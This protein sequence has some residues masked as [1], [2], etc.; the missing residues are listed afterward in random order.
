ME[1]RKV[2]I[3]DDEPDI[4]EILELL[5]TSDGYKVFLSADGENAIRLLKENPLMDLII[6]DVM[7]PHEDGI[8]VLRKIR[9]FS[10]IPALFL[11]AK[12]QESDKAEAYASG[13]DDFLEKPF[14]QNELLM[15]V[16]SLIRR[17]RDYSG[18]NSESVVTDVITIDENLKRAYKSGALLNLT[19]TEFDMLKFF[20]KNRG[21]PVDTKTLYEAVWDEKYVASAQNTIMVHILNLRKKIEDDHTNPVFLK[22][23][24]GKGYQFD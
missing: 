22:T 13:G 4:R 5:L 16:N 3:V 23:I 10:K 21:K 9:G 17:Y 12:T 2:L 8:T 1:Q 19:D 24:W 11:T 15:K 14:S 7:M 18:G 6:L 20:L